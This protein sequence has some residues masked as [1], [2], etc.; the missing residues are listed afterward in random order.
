LALLLSIAVIAYP[1]YADAQY[2]D[3]LRAEI[4]KL[5]PRARKAVELDR[6]IAITRNR[7]Q[8]LDAFRSRTKEDLDGLS[9]ATRLL[10][11]PT[12]L[13]SM[14]LSRDLV[15]VSG[16]AEQAAALLKVLDGSRQFR[17]STFSIPITRGQNG[18]LFT[19]HSTRQGVTP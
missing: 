14:V 12:W 7:A 4:H 1:K 2:L 17:G 19:I 13:T 10:T 6:Q 16:E 9:E 18:D 8:T 5:E 3:L 15:S 11:P